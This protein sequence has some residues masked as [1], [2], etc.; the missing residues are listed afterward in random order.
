MD[1]WGPDFKNTRLEFSLLRKRGQL[2]CFEWPSMWMNLMQWT[3]IFFFK[4]VLIATEM[5]VEVSSLCFLGTLQSCDAMGPRWRGLCC[6]HFVVCRSSLLELEIC[7][8][9]SA[10]GA[11]HCQ[12]GVMDHLMKFVSAVSHK[13]AEHFRHFVSNLT[14]ED[15][16]K[17]HQSMKLQIDASST[18]RSQH[19]SIEQFD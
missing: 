5:W 17:Q 14:V 13:K 9:R 3:N 2:E 1:A 6:D 11:Q 18:L 4:M 8:S 12:Y 7:R 10:F 16:L 15:Y 19:G